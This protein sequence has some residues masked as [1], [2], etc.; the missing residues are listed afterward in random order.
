[1][2]T[3]KAQLGAQVLHFIEQIEHG[4]EP[5]QIDA[6]NGAQVLDPPNGMDRFFREYHHPIRWLKD[7]SYKA[8]ATI[9]QNGTAGTPAR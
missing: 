4:F 3:Q 6:V 2:V 8:G 7:R 1:M 9:D 5:G